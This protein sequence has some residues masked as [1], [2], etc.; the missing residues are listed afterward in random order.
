MKKNITLILVSLL[1]GW[2]LFAT[3]TPLAPE[4]R[5]AEISVQM[6]TSVY[7]NPSAGTFFLEIKTDFSSHYEVKVVNL[8]G[9]TIKQERVDSNVVHKIDLNQVPKGVYFLQIDTGAEQVIKRLI[10]R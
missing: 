1:F 9:Q 2:Q 8:I 3:T 7:P 5:E 10:V 4:L 6:E